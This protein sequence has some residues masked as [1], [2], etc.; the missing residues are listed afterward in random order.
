MNYSSSSS[1]IANAASIADGSSDAFPVTVII[2]IAILSVL[3]LFVA[4]I[5][6]YLGFESAHRCLLAW[7]RLR[8]VKNPSETT[9]MV[10][11]ETALRSGAAA[12]TAAQPAPLSNE[13]L[14]AQASQFRFELDPDD[15][16]QDDIVIGFGTNDQ[17][18][19]NGVI[20]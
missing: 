6:I 9:E 18:Q 4:G 14:D 20:V 16:S 3:G 11:K 8:L 5:V 12:Q 19:L 13:Q 17:L 1:G 2:W 7:R 10:A 15:S